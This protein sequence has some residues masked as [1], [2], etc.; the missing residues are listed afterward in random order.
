[1]AP[2]SRN[3]HC[4]VVATPLL[5]VGLFFEPHRA[6][7]ALPPAERLIIT[8]FFEGRL[9]N[10]MFQVQQRADLLGAARLCSIFS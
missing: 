7:E 3:S 6:K 10:L 9:G 2:S 5:Q 8:T 4:S 1:M